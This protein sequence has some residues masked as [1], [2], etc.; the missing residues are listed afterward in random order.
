MNQTA[1]STAQT[2]FPGV[3]YR[4]ARAAVAW[5]ERAFGAA[6][7]VAYDGPDGTI[8]HAEVALAGNVIMLGSE[9]GDDFP[10]RSPQT[11]HYSTA[12]VYVVLPDAAAVDAMFARATAAG[13]TVQRAPNDTEYGS[14]ECGVLDCEGHPWGFGTYRPGTHQT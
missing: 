11:T 13:A 10:V 4:D 3:R 14:H 9:R 1:V 5:L 8:V 12:G 7:L 2:I 6:T